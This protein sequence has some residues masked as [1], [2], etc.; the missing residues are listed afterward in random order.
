VDRLERRDGRWAITA[1]VCV[2]EWITESTSSITEDVIGMLSALQK[3]TK[4]R[5]DPSYTRP[6]VVGVPAEP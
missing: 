1:R 4:D 5:T 6:L 2:V 3:P